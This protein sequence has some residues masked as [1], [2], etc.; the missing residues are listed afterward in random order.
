MPERASLVT[1][2]LILVQ[3]PVVPHSH[4][5]K[6]LR[7][8]RYLGR[9]ARAAHNLGVPFLEHY[10]NVGYLALRLWRMEKLVRR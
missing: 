10:Y 4:F 2:R 8:E 3:S 6:V 7:V 1:P 9:Q 5:H